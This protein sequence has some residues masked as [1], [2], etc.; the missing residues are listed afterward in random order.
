MVGQDRG[1]SPDRLDVALLEVT[2]EERASD[3]GQREGGHVA[4]D[5]PDLAVVP[6]GNA[7]LGLADHHLAPGGDAIVVERWLRDAPMSS[8]RLPLSEEEPVAHDHPDPTCSP[9][10][11]EVA[12]LRDED[13]VD[14]IR[15]GHQEGW[16]WPEAERHDAAK[17]GRD[18]GH[19]PKRISRLGREV[20]EQRHSLRRRTGTRRRHAD[21]VLPAGRPVTTNPAPRLNA[22]SPSPQKELN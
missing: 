14:R 15:I 1:R 9:G 22:T 18:A 17:F 6:P 16:I 19:E 21:T 3:D 11:P 12:A 2:V 4:M 7:G 8:P 13:L 5:V 20:A 10:L